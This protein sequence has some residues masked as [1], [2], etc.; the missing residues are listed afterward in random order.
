MDLKTVTLK[1]YNSIAFITLNRPENFN[2]LD[3]QLGDDL[4]SALEI[5][6]KDSTSRV[7][8]ITGA[9]KA[10][11]SGGDLKMAKEYAN[12]E[13]SEPY[14]QLTKKLNRI[15]TDIRLLNKP[16]IA[17]I[18]GSVGG[19]GLSIAAACD[20]RIASINAKFRQA[21]TNIGLVPDGAWTLLVPSLIGFGKAN[22]LLYLDPVF[23]A[24]KAL[25]IGLVNNIVEPECL[26]EFAIQM[27][28]KIAKGPTRSFVIIKNLV[29]NSL[30]TFLERQLELERQGIINAAETADY[31]E[32]INAFFDKRVPQFTGN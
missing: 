29:N 20:L 28:E 12:L 1:S 31:I 3:F 27:A 21:Y 32:G 23:D 25:E 4:I 30:F 13:P 10:F 15:I 18:N 6:Q 2:A 5:C 19:A 26:E 8:I 17:A 7:V 22:E 9:G 11:C 16:V 24:K 14:R